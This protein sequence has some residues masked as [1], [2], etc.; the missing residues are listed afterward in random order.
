MQTIIEKVQ[1]EDV[2]TGNASVLQLLH[3]LEHESRFTA[4]AHTDANRGFSRHWRNSNPPGHTRRK[5]NLLKIEDY[6]FKYVNHCE[7]LR[8][9]IFPVNITTGN[10]SCQFRLEMARK[11]SGFGLG[12]LN[13]V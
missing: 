8:L 12:R 3:K 10:N 13:A 7:N 1:I 11:I 2:L 5:V 6:F 4:A 9:S